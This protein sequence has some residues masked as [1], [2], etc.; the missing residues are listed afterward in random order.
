MPAQWALA[1]WR[2]NSLDQKFRFKTRDAAGVET[3]LDLTGSILVFRATQAGA[4][5]LRVDTTGGGFV[6]TNAVGGEAEL[7]LSVAESRLFPLGDLVRYE[8][9][10]RIG[11]AQKTLLFGKVIASEWANDDV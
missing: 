5:L 2:G 6:I 8:I 10:R 7:H 4:S 3:P 11:G 9:E 1:V